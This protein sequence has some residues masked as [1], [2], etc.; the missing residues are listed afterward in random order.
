MPGEEEVFASVACR[1]LDRRQGRGAS[2][3]RRGAGKA[4]G[5]LVMRWE[6]GERDTAEALFLLYREGEDAHCDQRRY[7]REELERRVG[8][9]LAATGEVPVYYLSALRALANPQAPR[10]G[11]VPLKALS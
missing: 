1:V 6:V 11:E 2:S 4:M 7:S 8:A 9:L 10:R 3:E 5:K